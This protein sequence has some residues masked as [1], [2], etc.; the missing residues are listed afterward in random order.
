MT[1]IFSKKCELGLQTVLFLSAQE[2]N[3]FFNA[4]FISK[5]LDIPKEF[6]SKVL[7]ILTVKGIVGSRK[8]KAGGFYLAKNPQDIKLLDI[9]IAIDGLEIFKTCLL[10]FK[11][12]SIEEPCPVHDKWGMLREQT[13]KILSEQTLEDLKEKT[14]NKINSL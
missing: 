10:G 6:A 12:C 14:I 9:V 4:S 2:K 8:G 13:I 3:K 1:V 5:K 7:Q 11:G